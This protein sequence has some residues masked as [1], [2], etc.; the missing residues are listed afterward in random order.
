MKKN[1]TLYVIVKLKECE[2][3]VVITKIQADK[4][5][6]V[7]HQINYLYRYKDIALNTTRALNSII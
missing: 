4:M 5:S 6:S 2:P 1:N 3:Y 7:Y